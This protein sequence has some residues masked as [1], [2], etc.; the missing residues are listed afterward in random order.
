MSRHLNASFDT[1]VLGGFPVTV[2]AEWL[3]ASYD[4]PAEGEI[5]LLLRNGK[6]ATFIEKK[7][8]DADWARLWDE[9]YDNAG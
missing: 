4:W 8:K 9:C 7:M 6:R 2:E 5:E 1:T 3:G